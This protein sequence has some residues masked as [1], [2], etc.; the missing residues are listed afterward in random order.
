MADAPLHLR[1]SHQRARSD[2]VVYEENYG[3]EPARGVARIMVTYLQRQA[4][5]IGLNIVLLAAAAATAWL[6]TTWL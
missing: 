2:A 1:R 6:G 5:Q 4:R 3:A